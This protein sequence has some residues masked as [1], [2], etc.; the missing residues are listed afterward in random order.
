MID[1][2][3][4]L[5][6]SSRRTL[7]VTVRQDG[8]VIVK[9][10]YRTSV[11]EIENFVQSK[12]GWVKKHLI[13]IE[14]SKSTISSVISGQ[15]VLVKGIEVPLKF[16]FKIS[17][18]SEEICVKSVKNLKKL[19]VDNLGDEFLGLFEYYKSAG[20]FDCNG[21]SFK[22]Y[23]SRWGC[24]DR[25]RRIIFN[26]KLLM[27]PRELW[28]LVIVHEL[29]HTVYM[30]HSREFHNLLEGLLPSAKLLRRRL[31]EYSLICSA[32]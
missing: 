12:S 26:Y 19:F 17:F 13:K 32:Y 29:C 3:Y 5:E 30:N 16:G 2:D 8:C 22:D 28:A 11:G 15:N 6:R 18:G 27:L 10:P 14:K 23:K 21:V 4:K 31:K 9:A 20:G 25:D 7:S 24:C 1:F